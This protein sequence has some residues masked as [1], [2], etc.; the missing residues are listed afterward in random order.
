MT[1]KKK[2]NYDFLPHPME[3]ITHDGE[4]FRAFFMTEEEIVEFAERFEKLKP[5][6]KNVIQELWDNWSGCD[7][8]WVIARHIAQFNK[9]NEEKYKA[10]LSK[11][12]ST[13]LPLPPKAI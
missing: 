6:I 11:I 2:Q 1:E 13:G 12:T 3:E 7:A 5:S 8:P 4:T 10:S 9:L